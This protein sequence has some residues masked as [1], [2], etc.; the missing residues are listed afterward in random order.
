MNRTDRIGPT[1]LQI[2]SR[3][4]SCGQE[5]LYFDPVL[6]CA[7]QGGR[8]WFRDSIAAKD[9]IAAQPQRNGGWPRKVTKKHEKESLFLCLFVPLCG[10]RI[11][12]RKQATKPLQCKDHTEIEVP[13]RSL[14]SFAATVRLK[15]L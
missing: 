4:P 5:I 7:H 15:P 9:L 13:L 10:L 11:F 14:R 8:R 6:P 1:I 3:L 2:L 12:A